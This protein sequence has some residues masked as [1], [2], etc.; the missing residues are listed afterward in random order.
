[1]ARMLRAPSWALLL[2]SGLMTGLGVPRKTTVGHVALPM[3]L[4]TGL[5]F[6]S[7]CG[8]YQ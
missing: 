2:S 8:P 5:S 1:M 7:V 6:Q 4:R 3:V